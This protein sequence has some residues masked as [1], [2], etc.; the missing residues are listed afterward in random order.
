MAQPNNSRNSS[1]RHVD[2]NYNGCFVACVAMA[3]GKTY[4][5][6]F[7]K[8]FPERTQYKTPI[9][10]GCT[11]KEAFKKLAH[12]G[13]KPRLL[14][15]N[16]DILKLNSTSLIWLRWPESMLMHSVLYE[17]EANKFWDPNYRSPLVEPIRLYNLNKFKE[18]IVALDGYIPPVHKKIVITNISY[19]ESEYNY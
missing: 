19:Y 13:L 15:G 14:S 16:L 17:Y 6:A 10:G 5:E 4:S 12:L 11:P 8:V 7:N 3:L 9:G 18:T 2:N 1:I